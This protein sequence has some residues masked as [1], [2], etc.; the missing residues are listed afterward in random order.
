MIPV[1]EEGSLRVSLLSHIFLFHIFANAIFFFFL[2]V[3][4]ELCE[5]FLDFDVMLTMSLCIMHHIGVHDMDS[6]Y[7]LHQNSTGL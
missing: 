4:K 3:K 7:N 6:Q 1:S 5:N 2:F